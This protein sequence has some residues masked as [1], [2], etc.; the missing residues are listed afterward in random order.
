MSMQANR[1]R[2]GARCSIT[3]AMVTL[4]LSPVSTQGQE[5][6][7]AFTNATIETTGKT[8]RIEKGTLVLRAGKIEAVGADIKIPDDARVIDARGK[9]I[10]PGILDPFR[11]V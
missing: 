11:E 3:L 5:A 6:T 4:T 8:G 9:T 7:V 2:S 10:M 1:A